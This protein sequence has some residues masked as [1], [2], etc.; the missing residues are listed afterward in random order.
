MLNT[1]EN[2]SN[3]FFGCHSIVFTYSNVAHRKKNVCN[4]IC[5]I[6]CDF[7]ISGSFNLN[8]IDNNRVSAAWMWNDWILILLLF[9]KWNIFKNDVNQYEYNSDE[10]KKLLKCRKHFKFRRIYLIS[11]ATN[12]TT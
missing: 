6:T 9:P 4:T 10:F 3:I 2:L 5:C 8:L 11:K 1:I 7:S 12:K